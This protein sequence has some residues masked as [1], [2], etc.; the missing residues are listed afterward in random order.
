MDEQQ[1]REALERHWVTQVVIVY[2]DRSYYTVSVMELADGKVVHETQY[3]SDPFDAP[4]WR[5]KWVEQ[6]PDARR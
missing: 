4:A 1:M 3:F 5:A 2:D 6:E